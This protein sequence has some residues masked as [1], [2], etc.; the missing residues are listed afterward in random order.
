MSINEGEEQSLEE[1][2]EEQTEDDEEIDT[3]GIF[4]KTLIDVKRLKKE[5]A[6]PKGKLYDLLKFYWM[7]LPKR[8]KTIDSKLT[9]IQQQLQSQGV[10]HESSMFELIQELEADGIFDKDSMIMKAYRHVKDN[11]NNNI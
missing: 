8:L 1:D 3:S 6:E 4:N 9:I 7:D 11:K 10:F 2:E 5:I